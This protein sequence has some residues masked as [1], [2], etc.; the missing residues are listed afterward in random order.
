MPSGGRGG[1]QGGRVCVGAVGVCGGGREEGVWRAGRGGRE[2]M[3]RREGR[4]ERKG[5]GEREERGRGEEGREGGS[6]GSG[7][8]VKGL[9]LRV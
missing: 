1:G 9:G 5:G 8:R 6:R 3:G 7:L 4:G 2:G